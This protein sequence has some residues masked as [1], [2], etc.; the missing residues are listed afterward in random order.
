MG[1]KPAEP[2]GQTQDGQGSS[3]ALS[4]SSAAIPRCQDPHTLF[5]TQKVFPTS[6][7]KPA[8]SLEFP[9]L[10]KSSHSSRLQCVRGSGGPGNPESQAC[11]GPHCYPQAQLCQR[12]RAP[13]AALPGR[14]VGD[15]AGQRRL[16]SLGQCQSL[17]MAVVLLSSSH[18]LPHR[19]LKSRQAPSL[20]NCSD[21]SAV[22][23]FLPG[24]HTASSHPGTHFLLT[25]SSIA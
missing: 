4:F 21:N 23:H 15:P 10:D 20:T 9:S 24:D 2:G 22:T 19:H 5:R 14:W 16:R 1:P 17:T 25:A 3:Q 6:P 7:L 13:N 11:L 8:G 12:H 18:L